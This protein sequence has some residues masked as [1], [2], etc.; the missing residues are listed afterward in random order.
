MRSVNLL[1]IHCSASADADTLARGT[2][3]TAGYT[4]PADTIDH[5]HRERGFHRAA[6]FRDRFNPELQAIGY[7]YVIGRDGALYTGRCEDEVG[8]HAQGFNRDSLGICLVGIER[9]TTAQWRVLEDLVWRLTARHGIPV[10]TPN[11][12]PSTDMPPL[13]RYRVQNG[14]CGHRELSPDKNGNGHIEP[15]EWLKT[16]PGFDVERW[17]ARGLVPEIANVYSEHV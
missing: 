9:F 4:S 13:P 7:H 5:W 15:F 12:V 16:C 10:R 17:L 6:F 14:V 1:V 3:G 8:A 11:R 2:P